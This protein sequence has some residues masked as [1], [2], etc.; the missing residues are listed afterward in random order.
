MIR[1]Q[2][3]E[4]V[5]Q[6]INEY[7]TVT[8]DELCNEFAVSKNTMRRDV[9]ELASHGYVKKIYGGVTVTE[10][11]Q[12]VSFQERNISNLDKKRKIGKKAATLVNSGEIIFIDSG[13]TTLHI[14]DYIKDLD[15]LTILTNSIEVIIKCIPYDNINLISLSGTLNRK[16]LSFTGSNT[17]EILRRYNI[18]RSFLAATGVSVNSGATNSSSLETEIKQT[19][20]LKSQSNYLLVDQNKFNVVS[21][22]TFSDFTDLDAIITDALPAS[23][24]EKALKERNCDIL[25]S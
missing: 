17:V 4:S 1:S 14:V 7:K 13:T 18:S 20:I 12:T 5:K 16:T 25:L 2:R 15:N 21:L 3:L 11:P 23:S 8:W 6:Y 22:M 24:L 10:I 19:A 9:D